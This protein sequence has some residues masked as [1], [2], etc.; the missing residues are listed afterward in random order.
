MHKKNAAP[1]TPFRNGE[2]I[3][4]LLKMGQFLHSGKS[5]VYLLDLF[6]HMKKPKKLFQNGVIGEALFVPFCGRKKYYDQ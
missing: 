2:G 3:S 4:N 1:I 5:K 6:L